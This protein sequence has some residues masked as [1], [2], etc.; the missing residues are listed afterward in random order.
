MFLQQEITFQSYL[1]F[2][3]EAGTRATAKGQLISECLFGALNFR[4]NQRKIYALETKKWT[5]QQ[6]K[7]IF[8]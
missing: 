1:I 5:N 3:Y 8:L 2:D 6:S 4:K 7:G